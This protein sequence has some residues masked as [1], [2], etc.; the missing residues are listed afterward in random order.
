VR[1]ES[2]EVTT[3]DT[4]IRLVHP[5]IPQDRKWDRAQAQAF[6]LRHIDLTLGKDR[7]PAGAEGIDIVLW[8]ESATGFPLGNNRG[9]QNLIAEAAG[10]ATVMAGSVRWNAEADGPANSVF[11]F[12]TAGSRP[13]VLAIY[14]KRRLVP[15]G[16]FVPL[17]SVLSVLGLDRFNPVGQ[18]FIAGDQA[19]DTILPGGGRTSILICYE[20]IFPGLIPQGD[21]RPDWV[22]HLTNDGWFGPSTGPLQHFERARLRAIETGLPIARAANNGVSG[23]I[24]PLGR[25][26]DDISTSEPQFLDVFLPNPQPQTYFQ[27]FK[28]IPVLLMGVLL[29]GAMR[30]HISL[31]FDITAR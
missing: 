24:D 10:G 21:R 7:T 25:V 12:S 2:A 5:S 27:I 22:A 23:L 8:P 9:A 15:F 1:L 4:Q 19:L 28:D 26:V 29:V 14:D 30:F 16:E 11:V 31:K 6:F 3:T 20:V 17:S 18:G 13:E